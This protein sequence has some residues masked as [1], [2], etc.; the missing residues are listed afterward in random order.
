MNSLKPCVNDLQTLFGEIDEDEDGLHDVKEPTGELDRI[1]ADLNSAY[2]A[3]A[4]CFCDIHRFQEIHETR[5]QLSTK[6]EQEESHNHCALSLLLTDASCCCVDEVRVLVSRKRQSVSI[7]RYYYC[8]LTFKYRFNNQTLHN[9]SGVR[10]NPRRQVHCLPIALQQNPDRSVFR[11]NLAIEESKYWGLV[12]SKRRFSPEDVNDQITFE[13]LFEFKNSEW[14]ELTK[15]VLAV[16][17]AHSL[18]YLNASPWLNG[19]WNRSSIVFYKQGHFLPARPFLRTQ[20]SKDAKVS[21]EMVEADDCFHRYPGILDFGI[22]LLEIH[23]GKRIDENVTTNSRRWGKASQVLF[24]EKW[25]MRDQYRSAVS[26]CLEPDFGLDA[27]C[28][29]QELHQQILKK[30]VKPLNAELSKGFMQLLKTN[31][32]D[33]VATKIDLISGSLFQPSDIHQRTIPSIAPL[34]RKY[35][36]AT[37]LAHV[38][39]NVTAIKKGATVPGY[40]ATNKFSSTTAASL[41]RSTSK[42]SSRPLSRDAFE[43][44]IICALQIE[45]D[46]V[47]ALLDEEYE[48][49]GFSYGKASGDPNAYTTG[50]IGYHHVVLAYMP[51]MGKISAAVVA[52]NIRS[53][54]KGITVGL[55]VGICG[56]VPN[57]ADGREIL[58][59]DVIISTSVVHIDFGRQYPNKFVRKDAVED[60]LGRANH[61]IRSVLGKV[62]GYLVRQRLKDKTSIYSTRI[63]TNEAFHKARYPGPERDKLYQSTYR[64]KHQNPNSCIICSDCQGQDDEVCE[65][66]LESSCAELSCDDGFLVRRQRLQKAMGFAP[67]GGRIVDEDLIREAQKSSIHFGRI[68]SGDGVMK[69]GQHRDRIAVEEKVIGFEMESAGTWDYIPTVVIKSVCDYADNHKNKEWQDYAAVTAAACTRAFLEEWRPKDDGNYLIGSQWDVN[70]M[71]NDDELIYSGEEEEALS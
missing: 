20:I 50:R 29:P 23:T 17:L 14:R 70:V 24:E 36:T 33:E 49:D 5:L 34:G 43:I 15:L 46:A 25:N 59:G 6:L 55:V 32:L 21:P 64:H 19:F 40:P 68:A 54:F 44:A 41:S 53:S 31:P 28:T 12:P 39:G 45:R 38:S 65:T 13:N 62:S 71:V 1:L 3:I 4:S 16:I 9:R 22:A 10:G 48:T 58:L 56:G 30:V 26:A 66:A 27:N 61:E 42:L 2:D 47:E 57:T 18:L 52:S 67:G 11:A 60:T 69:S 35:T 63:C 8:S 7:P 37:K 51:A